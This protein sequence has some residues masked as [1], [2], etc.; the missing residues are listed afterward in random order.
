MDPAVASVI[1]A[2]IA[3]IGSIIGILINKVKNEVVSAKNETTNMRK[4]NKED[5]AIVSQLLN[6]VIRDVHNIDEKLDS[7]IQDHHKNS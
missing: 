5:H 1:V 4:E 3:A 2:G 7:H 6:I